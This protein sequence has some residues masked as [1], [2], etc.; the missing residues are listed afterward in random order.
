MTK[1]YDTILPLRPTVTDFRF[2]N[3]LCHLADIAGATILVPRHVNSTQVS[4][5][6]WGEYCWGT[7]LAQ[8]DKHE[9]TKNIVLEYWFPST[10]T[11]MFST[12]PSPGSANLW[13]WGTRRFHLLSMGAPVPSSNGLCYHG[14]SPS[15]G[16]QGDIPYCIWIQCLLST[17]LWIVSVLYS[18][19]LISYYI[20]FQ[21][22]QTCVCSDNIILSHSS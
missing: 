3:G 21:V 16:C 22:I 11:R 18:Y 13:R 4:A 12:R 10:H 19:L 2:M 20:Q 9:Y 14:N 8:N 17:D 1:V 6:G 15:N 7:R 5:Q